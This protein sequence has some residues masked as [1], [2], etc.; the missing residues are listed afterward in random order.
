MSG[1]L[2]LHLSVFGFVTLDI[3]AGA[4]SV[5]EVDMFVAALLST[6]VYATVAN[7]RHGSVTGHLR[8]ARWYQWFYMS[9]PTYSLV[10]SRQFLDLVD[11][12]VDNL[13]A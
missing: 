12:T 1:G 5:V 7:T 8:P 2:V 6:A 4:F 11:D 9:I 13:L 10:Y 3:S